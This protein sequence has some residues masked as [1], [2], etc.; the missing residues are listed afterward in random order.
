MNIEKTI[1][2]LLDM[3]EKLLPVMNNSKDIQK[4]II[5]LL[6]GVN[7]LQIPVI[8]TEQYPEGLGG[9][10]SEIS[11][12]LENAKYFS[13]KEFSAFSVIKDEILKLKA[14]G[15]DEIVVSGIETH[16]CVYQTIRDLVNEGFKVFVPFETVSSRERLNYENGLSL[17]K[18]EGAYISNVETILFD[19]I[20][21]SKHSSFKTI[22]KLIK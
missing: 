6:K 3:Q 2:L 5:T 14:Q 18:R 16:I 17:L 12:L 20:K 15:R 10:L 8:Y 1:F 7:E 22:S 21:S 4:N 13:K 9:T 11:D 19:L